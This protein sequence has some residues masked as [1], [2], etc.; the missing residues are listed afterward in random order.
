L[1]S[2]EGGIK[3][4]RRRTGKKKARQ[5]AEKTAVRRGFKSEKEQG[6]RRKGEEE[7]R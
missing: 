1:P 3:G 5:P 4:K 6:V 7:R 2:P